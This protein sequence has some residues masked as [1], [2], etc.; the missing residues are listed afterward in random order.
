MSDYGICPNCGENEG[1]VGLACPNELCAKKG[2]YFIPRNWYEAAL[3]YYKRKHKALDS[4]LGKMLDDKYLLIGLLGEGGMGTVYLGLEVD[5]DRKVAIKL[6]SGDAV[7]EDQ[8]N[9]QNNQAIMKPQEAFA[10]FKR[11]ARALALLDHPNIVKLFSFGYGGVGSREDPMYFEAPYIVMGYIKHAKTLV[12][13]FRELQEQN[14]G[15]V[16]GEAVQKVFSQVLNALSE[17]HSVGI[18]HRDLKPDNILVT[19][20]KGN[21]LFVKLLDFGLAKAIENLKGFDETL[22]INKIFGTPVYMAPEQGSYATIGRKSQ[23]DHRADL[24]A[25]A[26]ML[27]ETFTGRKPFSGNSAIAILRQKVAPDYD[28]MALDEARALPE[29]V[30]AFLKKGLAVAPSR[31]FQSAEEMRDA[32]AQ[33]FEAKD[34]NGYAIGTDGTTTK[35]RM[36]TPVS[37]DISEEP[38]TAMEPDEVDEM[39]SDGVQVKPRSSKTWWILG[40]LVALAV[41]LGAVLWGLGGNTGHLRSGTRGTTAIVHG[42]TPVNSH[43]TGKKTAPKGA[44]VQ[45]TAPRHAKTAEAADKPKPAKSTHT[46]VP[47]RA[48]VEFVTVPAGARVFMDN[49]LLGR[50]RVRWE[51]PKGRGRVTIRVEAPDYKSRTLHLTLQELRQKGTLHVTLKRRVPIKRKG[52]KK[53]FAVPLI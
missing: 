31:R 27:Y 24:Y 30:Q 7:E 53:K 25:V 49:K 51:V 46:M 26:V 42:S 41:L 8:G 13:T 14:N 20:V 6:I 38:T 29:K 28:P 19:K 10:R 40:G 3:E 39:L 50:G 4:N 12:S 17:A 22:T 43:A 9:G 18:V 21:P 44:V 36:P 2:Y 16:P 52:R 48:F 15:V 32:L 35:G 34:I 33:V 47:R 37:R 5:L 11:E 1:F 45:K 23:V